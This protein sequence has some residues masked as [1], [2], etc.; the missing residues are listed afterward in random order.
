MEN[1]KNF[2]TR[3]HFTHSL[4]L[5][6]TTALHSI[7][8]MPDGLCLGRLTL[9]WVKPKRR[10][11]L[12]NEGECLAILGN[13]DLRQ[14][15]CELSVQRFGRAAVEGSLGRSL[16]ANTAS[17]F[18]RTST[19]SQKKKSW[20]FTF[21]NC[22]WRTR[23]P[24]WLNSWGGIK[25]TKKKQP[26]KPTRRA[27]RWPHAPERKQERELWWLGVWKEQESAVFFWPAGTWYNIY[28][29]RTIT[30]EHPLGHETLYGAADK[31]ANWGRW[32][33]MKDVQTRDG[34][35]KS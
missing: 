26:S 33:A 6:S 30:E 28:N 15:L 10:E 25:K 35:W 19:H 32:P 17:P 2:R 27:T 18:L 22:G 1:N 9:R 23:Q 29:T 31:V 5:H 24:A 16:K 7:S 12:W 20:Y 13:V 3:W 4:M 14:S 34:G 11:K 21:E 8:C